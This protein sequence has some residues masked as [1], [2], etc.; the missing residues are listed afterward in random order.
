MQPVK[1]VATAVFIIIFSLLPISQEAF[2]NFSRRTDT[3]E[4]FPSGPPILERLSQNS[5]VK[6]WEQLKGTNVALT[7]VN[8]QLVTNPR[9]SD[10]YMDKRVIGTVKNNS[11]KGFS[12]VKVEFFVYDE[13][14]N[15]IA[16]VLS[17]HYDFKPGD[18][19]KFQIPVTEDVEKAELKGLYVHSNK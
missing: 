12:E 4:I 1:K 8:W 9:S 18:I 7:L 17:N 5:E 6:Y 14:G 2:A 10:K 15:Q 19:W 13:D 16:I 3:Q 11:K